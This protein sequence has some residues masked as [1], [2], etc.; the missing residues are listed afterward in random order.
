M[1]L[2]NSS[3]EMKMVLNQLLQTRLLGNNSKVAMKKMKLGMESSA[4]FQPVMKN[5]EQIRA[6][7]TCANFQ[8][9]ILSLDSK[10]K[11]FPSCSG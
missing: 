7:S 2:A 5:A 10:K 4:Q 8:K 9:C 3:L 6:D 1:E 11:M